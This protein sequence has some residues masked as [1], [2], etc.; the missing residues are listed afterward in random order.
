MLPAAIERLPE[1]GLLLDVGGW[2][3]PLARADWVVDLMP[4]ATRGLYGKVEH[5]RFSEDTW[6]EHD[7]CTPWPFEDG[8]FDFAVCSH[9]LEDI[10]DPVF[11]CRELQRVAKA[12]YV[13]VPSRIE[14]QMTGVNGAWPGWA[15]HRWVIEI[16]GDTITFV[17][18]SHAMPAIAYAELPAERRNQ[19][20]WWD[21]SFDARERIMTS[22]EE[23][24]A[25][26]SEAL[27][28]IV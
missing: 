27:R 15:H 3:S 13:E 24:D 20:L 26:F 12:G 21:G 14:E 11:A 10:R 22:I 23:H 4:Y 2:A 28:A 19:W 25:Y 6:V 16:A 18:K 17:H 1:D 7:I 5:E 8:Q 9:T